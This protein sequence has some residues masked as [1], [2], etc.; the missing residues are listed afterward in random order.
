MRYRTASLV[1]WYEVR[2]LC[3]K[4]TCKAD[5]PHGIVFVLLQ[6]TSY[7]GQIKY[8][9]SNFGVLRGDSPSKTYL[10]GPDI[11]ISG[12][13]LV[14]AYTLLSPILDEE[15]PV[16]VVEHAW[17]HARSGEL[18]TREQFMKVLASVSHMILV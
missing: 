14:L 2:Q 12:N 4:P 16:D 18:V 11:Q 13:N 6:L 10:P 15:I 5:K 1:L 9:V 7:G 17:R 3:L 8:T